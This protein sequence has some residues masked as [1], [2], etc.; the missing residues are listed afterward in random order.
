MEENSLKI[1][2]QMSKR[3]TFTILFSSVFFF[4]FNVSVI[5]VNVRMYI[6]KTSDR[7]LHRVVHNSISFAITL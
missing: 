6:A 3:I 1:I 7:T 5:Y 4:F 2:S